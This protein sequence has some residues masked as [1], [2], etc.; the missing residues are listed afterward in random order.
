MGAEQ[1]KRNERIRSALHEALDQLLTELLGLSAGGH[2]LLEIH[3]KD[4]RL[5][6]PKITQGRTLSESDLDPAT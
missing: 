5:A 1:N 3:A 2:V 4:G 6:L